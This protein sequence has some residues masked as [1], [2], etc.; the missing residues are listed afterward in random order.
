MEVDP[1]TFNA[2]CSGLKDKFIIVS[3]IIISFSLTSLMLSL[4]VAATI[5]VYKKYKIPTQKLV[6]YLCIAAGLHAT[7][8]S[9]AAGAHL[10]HLNPKTFSIYCAASGFAFQH[11]ASIFLLALLVIYVDMYLR[12]VKHKDTAHFHIFYILII[13][14]SPIL[15]NW[16]PFIESSYGEIGPWCWIRDTNNDSNCTQHVLGFV[17]QIGLGYAPVLVGCCVALALYTLM[18]RQ[19]HLLKYT[20]KHDP[21]MEQLRKQL[22]KEAT[23]SFLIYPWIFLIFNTIVFACKVA[24]FTLGHSH[25]NII[26]PWSIDAGIGSI[27]GGIAVVIFGLNFETLYYLL[28]VKAYLCCCQRSVKEYPV[29]IPTHTDSLINREKVAAY[30]E[31][32]SMCTQ[33]NYM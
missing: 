27:Q 23:S 6:L 5:L 7:A 25:S 17:F 19:L 28:Q 15:L 22:L 30:T 8:R 12:I 29:I 20:G 1:D 3:A 33:N 18:V 16:I 2:S 24:A 13:F 14:V 32:M 4:F 26:V 9:L 31:A 21:Q 11:T 10:V